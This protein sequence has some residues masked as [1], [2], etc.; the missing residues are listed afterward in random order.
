V[1]SFE[2]IKEETPPDLPE[3]CTL[4]PDWREPG[5]ALCPERRPLEKLQRIQQRNAYYFD[6]LFQQRPRPRDG[7]LFP[8]AGLPLVDAAPR[9]MTRV[10]YWDKAGAEPGKGDWT[11]GVLMGR[12]SDG[13]FW[14]EDVVRGQWP[15]DER[16]KTIKQT[17]EMDR[18]KYG[19]VK[20]YVERPPGLAKESAEAVVKLLAGFNAEVDPVNKD[21][22]E[23]AEPLSAQCRAGNVK[24]VKDARWNAAYLSV[25][26]IFPF[27]SHDDDVD[28]SS[29]AFNKLAVGG[30]EVIITD[31]PFNDGERY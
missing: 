15:A 17:A 4:E 29:G 25:M 31:N 13:L 23:R 1:V 12:C 6:A 27:G 19:R 10:R 14:I 21:K 11:V 30:G 5:E 18:L 9:L 2:A 26:T 16:N 20:V 7:A 28:A 8:I 3:S 22:V 24:V